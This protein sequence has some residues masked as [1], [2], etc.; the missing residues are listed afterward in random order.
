MDDTESFRFCLGMTEDNIKKMVY[1][2]L[3]SGYSGV[4]MIGVTG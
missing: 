1:F 2:R 4:I 3:L